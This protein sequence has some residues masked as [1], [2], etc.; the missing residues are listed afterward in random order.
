MEKYITY[1]STT[2]SKTLEIVSTKE[3]D[4]TD[5]LS[6]KYAFVKVWDSNNQITLHVNPH[7]VTTVKVT[8]Y[9]TN[10]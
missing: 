5:L 8:K 10:E 1:I 2:D 9:I 3:L 6:K 7:L 4:L